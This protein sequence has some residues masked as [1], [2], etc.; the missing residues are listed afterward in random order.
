MQTASLR[1]KSHIL[2]FFNACC[3]GLPFKRPNNF[4][5]HMFNKRPHLFPPIK[6]QSNI[7]KRLFKWIMFSHRN[8][9]WLPEFGKRE[10]Q[11]FRISRYHSNLKLVLSFSIAAE[12]QLIKES[13]KTW[14]LLLKKEGRI[15]GLWS[16]WEWFRPHYRDIIY[17]HTFM[18]VIQIYWERLN[19]VK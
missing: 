5:R 14:L 7:T 16:N 6:F 11:P 12:K 8:K 19:S 15:S 13:I 1:L 17:I 9:A 4:S 18:L 10:K 3:H 2:G